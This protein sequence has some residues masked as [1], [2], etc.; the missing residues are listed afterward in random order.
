[1]NK[2][3]IIGNSKMGNQLYD[4]ITSKNN[5]SVTLIS[6][7]EFLSKKFTF[8]IDSYNIVIENVEEVLDTKLKV[9]EKIYE[10]YKNTEFKDTIICSNT[11]SIPLYQ[12]SIKKDM[13]IIGLHFFNPISH[14]TMV[15]VLTKDIEKMNEAEYINHTLSR[16][17]NFCYSLNLKPVFINSEVSVV[18][19]I[20]FAML[21][22]AIVMHIETKMPFNE[23]DLIMKDS[24]KHKLGPFE[25]M[26]LIGVKTVI[27]IFKDNGRFMNDP[28]YYQVL[29]TLNQVSYNKFCSNKS[30]HRERNI[31]YDE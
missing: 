13:C 22:E 25:L 30:K 2:V 14:S 31:V 9:F 1:M 28:S 27:N 20:L 21:Y 26:E 6:C 11:S 15:E 24:C 18:N 16:V 4:F 7:T 17:N 5:F 23:I 3:L 10:S 19:Q 12:L 8:Y 29:Y